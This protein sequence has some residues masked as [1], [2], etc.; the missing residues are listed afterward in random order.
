MS[1]R[2]VSVS[3]TTKKMQQYIMDEMTKSGNVNH[4]NA[5]YMNEISKTVFKTKNNQLKSKI[6]TPDS[7]AN[8]IAFQIVLNFF[9]KHKILELTEDSLN[10]ELDNS[11]MKYGSKGKIEDLQFDEETNVMPS[12]LAWNQERIEEIRRKEEEAKEKARLEALLAEERAQA[13]QSS[14]RKTSIQESAFRERPYAISTRD[15]PLSPA[16][17]VFRRGRMP[18]EAQSEMPASAFRFVRRETQSML[19]D[20]ARANNS[21]PRSPNGK[22]YAQIYPRSVA[23]STFGGNRG[24]PSVVSARTEMPQRTQRVKLTRERP[25]AIQTDSRSQGA[26][27]AN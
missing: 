20:T 12:F 16:G 3:E 9:K 22:S 24:A 26:A 15:M 18:N 8:S 23:N 4:I 21:G 10:L 27:S 6:T 2:K 17:E 11:K 19:P 14:G 13:S 5:K 25:A 1:E 7:K